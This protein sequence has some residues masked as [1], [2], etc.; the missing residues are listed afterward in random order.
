MTWLNVTEYIPFVVIAI[1]SF[2]HSGHITKFLRGVTRQMPLVKQKLFSL[3]EQSFFLWTSISVC[4]FQCS[5]L[6]TINFFWPLYCLCFEVRLPITLWYICCIFKFFLHL[7]KIGYT[8]W[9]QNIWRVKI[10]S[11]FIISRHLKY[12]QNSI[13][14]FS[15]EN[16]TLNLNKNKNFWLRTHPSRT[17]IVHSQPKVPQILI[18]VLLPFKL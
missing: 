14:D 12:K 16:I 8:F 1:W 18:L 10:N 4:S 2:P 17:V 11:I 3:P 5:I 9:L 6:S 15:K 13:L 7:Y